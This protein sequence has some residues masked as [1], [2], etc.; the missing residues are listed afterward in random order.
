VVSDRA[1]EVLFPLYAVV[2]ITC[3]LLYGRHGSPSLF[4]VNVGGVKTDVLLVVDVV[5]VIGLMVLVLGGV[6]VVEA[7]WTTEEVEEV[8]AWVLVPGILLVFEVVVFDGEAVD[9]FGV[10]E[11][12]LI[13]ALEDE[14]L[15]EWV[16]V[17]LMRPA[18]VVAPLVELLEVVV[19]CWELV[20]VKESLDE[21]EALALLLVLNVEVELVI[22]FRLGPLEVEEVLM[23][24]DLVT[25][26]LA[27]ALL[28]EL[29]EVVVV[30][31]VTLVLAVELWDVDVEVVCEL[32][33]ALEVCGVEELL[34]LL[35]VLVLLVFEVL[36]FDGEVEELDF[37]DDEALLLVVLVVDEEAVSEWLVLVV[38]VDDLATLVLVDEL[39]EVVVE[40]VLGRREVLVVCTRGDEDEEARILVVIEVALLV[41]EVIVEGELEVEDVF[42]VDEE[43][44]VVERVVTKRVFD[45]VEWVLVVD[46]VEE[47]EVT[48]RFQ[49]SKSQ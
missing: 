26:V 10:D 9:V 15:V 21:L 5:D 3:P 16:L 14:V 13:V 34:A 2:N 6:L 25:L 42:G 29:L 12:L 30:D 45:V 35:P 1:W 33:V 23:V 36:T 20:V 39:W 17:I 27:V 4:H 40:V 28:V 19:V 47:F 48:A 8:V 37:P 46:R 44:L 22:G 32:V 43:L 38:L 49:C 7:F 18:L 24:L 11:L 41:L 31:F